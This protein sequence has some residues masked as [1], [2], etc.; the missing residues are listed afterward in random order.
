MWPY[1]RGYLINSETWSSYLS[2]AILVTLALLISL[3]STG[4]IGNSSE[5]ITN[6]LMLFPFLAILLFGILAMN[7]G[8]LEQTWLGPFGREWPLYYKH[9]ALQLGFLMLLMLPAWVVYQGVH[10]LPAARMLWGLAHLF[11]YGVLAGLFGLLVGLRAQSEISQ[12]NI[13]YSVFLIFLFLTALWWQ[14]LNPFFVLMAIFGDAVLDQSGW[15]FVKSYLSLALLISALV[16][17]T[18]RQILSLEEVL[19]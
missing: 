14:P 4:K 11:V 16:W 6:V 17:L 5:V 1:E 2:F 9:L 12:F 15:F 13:K 19:L 18:R 10:H 7:F 8:Q 3:P